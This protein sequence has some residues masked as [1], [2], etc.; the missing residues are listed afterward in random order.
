MTA[1]ASTPGM[2]AAR[3]MISAKPACC[4]SGCG[5]LTLESERSVLKTCSGSKPGRTSLRSRKLLPNNPAPTNSTS[6]SA[7]S[8]T[9]KS[10][11]TRLG[12]T[13]QVLRPPSLSGSWRSARL[14][15][16]AGARPKI[17]PVKTETTA[18]KVST[19]VS[20]PTSFKRGMFS[21]LS[22]NKKWR[23]HHATSR[24]SPPP[25]SESNKLSVRSCRTTRRRPAPS[26][27]RI[28]ISL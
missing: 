8:I 27:T 28:A 2:A 14:A 18:V 16:T 26:A 19:V 6:E 4:C 20:N 3:L 17:T 9:T 25:K 10:A 5:Y 23:P 21:E 11:R 22:A 24:P 1:A 12:T 15:C 13:P 7:T